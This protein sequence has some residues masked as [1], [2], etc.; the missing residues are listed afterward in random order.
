MPESLLTRELCRDQQLCESGRN[1]T[2]EGE[3]TAEG[4][5]KLVNQSVGL[6][7]LW[8]LTDQGW[9]GRCWSLC[10]VSTCD[11]PNVPSALLTLGTDLPLART[12]PGQLWD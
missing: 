1:G 8:V 3:G 12:T 5:E 11:A 10:P 6:T 2:A 9:R 4:P 7:S